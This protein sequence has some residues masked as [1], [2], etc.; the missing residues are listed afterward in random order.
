[1]LRNGV[2]RL[3][4]M[5]DATEQAFIASLATRR[6]YRDGELVHERGDRN[7]TVGVVVSGKIKLFNPRKTGLDVFSGLIHAGQSF[8]DAGLMYDELRIHRAVAFGDTVID[9]LGRAAFHK[10]LERPPILRALYEISSFRLATT[11]SLLD[12]FR[13]LS[14]E[15]RLARLLSRMNAAVNRTGRLD[16]LQ[17]E[18]A[19]MLGMSTVTLAKSLRRLE[20][21]NL[22]KPGYRHIQIP[23]AEAL[24]AWILEHDGD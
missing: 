21:E 13:A 8:G 14:P 18:I 3:S 9:H 23:D 17:E 12:D 4:E 11:M 15:L 6:R 16:F 7:D 5:L 20:Q 2:P 1:L 19:G 24:E 22:L 10:L